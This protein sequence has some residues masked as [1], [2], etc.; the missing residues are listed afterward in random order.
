[1]KRDDGFQEE[2]REKEIER[3]QRGWG[4]EGRGDVSDF[5]LRN[6]PL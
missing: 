5:G 1:M 4:D 3:Q 6:A 2:K